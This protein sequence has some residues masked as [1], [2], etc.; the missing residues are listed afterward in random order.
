MSAAAVVL[1][2][3]FPSLL[4][5]TVCAEI[6]QTDPRARVQAIVRPKFDKEANALLEELP[7]DQRSRVGIVEGDAAAIDM[8]L[9][10][11]RVQVALA[12]TSRTFTTARR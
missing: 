1:L 6:V 5:R 9:S 8:G 2:T 11:A 10:G 12:A 7:P 3:G 4:A